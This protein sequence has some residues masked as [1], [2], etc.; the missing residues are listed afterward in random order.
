MSGYNDKLSWKQ[1]YREARSW[2]SLYDDDD[3]NS[4]DQQ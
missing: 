1:V 4:N 2:V 3:N